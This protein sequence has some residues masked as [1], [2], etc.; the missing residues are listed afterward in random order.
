[1]ASD[2]SLSYDL[3][4]LHLKKIIDRLR[5][6]LRNL[7]LGKGHQNVGTQNNRVYSDIQ[8]KREIRFEHLLIEKSLL[9][10][11]FIMRVAVS[12]L[13]KPVLYLW[14]LSLQT[15]QKRI[16]RHLLPEIEEFCDNYTF[17]TIGAPSHTSRSKSV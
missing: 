10:T 17:R 14:M 6:T 4:N 8:I 3:C 15:Y 11:G 5:V 12:M 16:L 1:M 13:G 7:G 9:T 2:I